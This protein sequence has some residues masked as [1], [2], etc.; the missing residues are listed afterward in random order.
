MGQLT[1]LFVLVFRAAR[2]LLLL[3]WAALWY[4]VGWGVGVVVRVLVLAVIS[5]LQGFADA[6]GWERV[7]VWK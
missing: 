4:G 7:L 5:S 2:R 6:T 1:R 3:L